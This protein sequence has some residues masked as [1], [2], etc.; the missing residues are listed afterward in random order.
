[1]GTDLWPLFLAKRC[2]IQFGAKMNDTIAKKV[3]LAERMSHEEVAQRLAAAG[4]AVKKDTALRNNVG[5]MAK[6]Q[7][8]HGSYWGIAR[9]VYKKMLEDGTI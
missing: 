6:L 1:M 8:E 5:F 3:E 4:V 7:T 9:N 2:V